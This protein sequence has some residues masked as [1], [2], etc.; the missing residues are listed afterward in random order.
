ML[1]FWP[2]DG[3]PRI[4]YPFPMT[5]AEQP[6]RRRSSRRMTPGEFARAVEK[7][8]ADTAA[9]AQE[10]LEHVH[11]AILALPAFTLKDGTTA[12]VSDLAAPA[13]ND[14]GELVSGFDVDLGNG[15]HLEFYLK[16]TGWGKSLAAADAPKQPRQGPAR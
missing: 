16:N 8:K 11:K 9:P 7:L 12:R 6:P 10:V 2:V 14:D 13:M 3:C 4:R 1:S 5:D 15:G